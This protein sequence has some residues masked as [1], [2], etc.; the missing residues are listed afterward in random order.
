M[1]QKKLAHTARFSAFPQERKKEN[2]GRKKA[3]GVECTD[4][5][6]PDGVPRIVPIYIASLY[7][8]LNAFEQA[9]ILT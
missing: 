7:A 2:D 9:I 1:Q 8:R 5:T 4:A 3:S 6:V